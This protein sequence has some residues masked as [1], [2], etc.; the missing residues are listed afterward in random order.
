MAQQPNLN[1]F[2]YTDEGGKVWNKRGELDPAVNAIDGSTPLTAGAPLWP[3]L[4][5]RMQPRRGL[6][7]DPVTRRT[8]T[9]IVYTHAAGQ[10]LVATPPTL[11][12]FIQG[13]TAAVPYT[14]VGLLPEKQPK[15]RTSINLADHA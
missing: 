2:T 4:T 3:P 8:S 1:L 9:I 10:A 15:I 6:F 14:F 11:S 7:Q 12:R 5:R 13:N